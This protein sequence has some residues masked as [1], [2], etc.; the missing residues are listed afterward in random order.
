MITMHTYT[1]LKFLKCQNTNAAVDEI[2]KVYKFVN[3][4]MSMYISQIVRQI[5]PD[6]S[7]EFHVNHLPAENLMKD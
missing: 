4:F 6:I 1:I 3:N 2:V 5:K 7:Y